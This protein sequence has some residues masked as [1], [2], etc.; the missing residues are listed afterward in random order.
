MQIDDCSNC[1]TCSGNCPVPAEIA[2][3]MISGKEHVLR[4]ITEIGELQA[5]APEWRRLEQT[6]PEPFIYFQSFDWCHQWCIHHLASEEADPEI[7]L[8]IYVLSAG[9]RIAMIW[10]MVRVRSRAGVRILVSLTDPL[11]QYSNVLFDRTRINGEIGRAAWKMICRHAEVDAVTLNHFP[12]GSFLDAILLG[13]GFAER[14]NIAA[15]ILDLEEFETWAAYQQS[16]SKSTRKSRRR[17]RARLEKE[18]RLA[19]EVVPG[20]SR[21]YRELVERTLSMKREWLAQT[22]RRSSSISSKTTGSFIADLAGIQE[23]D[24]GLPQGAFAHALTLDGEV[25]ATEV[26]MVAGRHYYSFLGAF[27]LNWQDFSPGKIQIE[28]AQEWAKSVGIDQFDFL[29]DPS[30]YKSHW[31]GSSVPLCSRSIPL[32]ATG[33]VYCAIWKSRLRPTLKS[34]YHNMDPAHRRVFT[35]L[36]AFAANTYSRVFDR[37]PPSET[38]VSGV[39]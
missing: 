33:F 2:S 23:N 37:N 22:G 32:T 13:V 38:T 24:D 14:S 34:V 28:M 25:I 11:G 8:R 19:Y 10:P 20:G 29:G 3:L 4:C 27:D 6:N 30:S 36:L 17:R 31:T 15:S 1:G 7:Q 12:V 5:I 35:A 26:G 16:L 21:R 9:D 18:G 39:R